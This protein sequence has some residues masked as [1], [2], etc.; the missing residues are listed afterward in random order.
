M[1]LFTYQSFLFG[2]E[3]C[4]EDHQNVSN[5]GCKSYSL[6]SQVLNAL[7]PQINARTLDWDLVV[8][9]QLGM[10]LLPHLHVNAD[11][12]RGKVSPI[13]KLTLIKDIASLQ[14]S[15]DVSKFAGADIDG[16][17]LWL[18][19]MQALQPAQPAQLPASRS[20]DDKAAPLLSSLFLLRFHCY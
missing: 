9:S 15:E 4:Y 12:K 6:I 14:Q 8:H 16:W 10:L 18:S 11:L 17:K 5:I 2:L 19:L 20:Q 13:S 1:Q 7:T 3:R